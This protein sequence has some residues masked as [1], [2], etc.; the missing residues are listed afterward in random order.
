MRM[1]GKDLAA[2]CAAIRGGTSAAKNCRGA[3]KKARRSIQ[4]VD[5]NMKL[6]KALLS[7]L[8]VAAVAGTAAVAGIAAGLKKW[9]NDEDSDSI[10]LALGG[11]KG[12]AILKGEKPGTFTVDTCYD[13]QNDP[14]FADILDDDEDDAE[15]GDPALFN[16]ADI[17]ELLRDEETAA[18]EVEVEKAEPENGEAEA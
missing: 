14:E 18:P 15:L 11:K 8:G 10:K 4:V 13:W 1:T 7:V 16:D 5:K 6:T 17:E 3:L 12:L 2:Y 9:A